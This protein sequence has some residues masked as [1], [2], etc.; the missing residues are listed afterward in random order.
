MPYLEVAFD[1]IAV[2][3][4]LSSA[5][6]NVLADLGFVADPGLAFVLASSAFDPFPQFAAQP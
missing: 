5:G 1:G 3:I 4:L 6:V 2:K